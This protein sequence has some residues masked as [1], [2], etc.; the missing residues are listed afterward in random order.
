[1]RRLLRNAGPVGGAVVVAAVALALAFNLC[2]LDRDASD[3]DDQAMDI[4]AIPIV[5]AASVSVLAIRV[6]TGRPTD[7][8]SRFVS[9]SSLHL[10]DPPPK[11]AVAA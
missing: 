7:E 1:M 4:C 3:V 10:P 6:V 9:D 2:A 5:T 11:T 8:L